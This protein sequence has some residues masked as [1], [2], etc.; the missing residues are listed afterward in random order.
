MMLLFIFLPIFIYYIIHWRMISNRFNNNNN[1]IKKVKINSISEMLHNF[2][3]LYW[4][5][6]LVSASWTLDYYFSSLYHYYKK[7]QYEKKIRERENKS[8][9]EI[10][11]IQYIV[12]NKMLIFLFI[13][14][15]F[16][17]FVVF[18]T[19]NIINILLF[20]FYFLFFTLG[21]LFALFF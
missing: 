19:A 18:I 2:L 20:Y 16:H 15:S 5:Y 13:F 21:N 3:R 11:I 6:I 8:K 17:F 7:N 10:L 9:I 4:F 1:S 12:N 14:F